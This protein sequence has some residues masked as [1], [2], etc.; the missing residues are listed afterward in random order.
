MH[1]QL[2]FSAEEPEDASPQKYRWELL[3]ETI[4]IGP[5][6]LCSFMLWRYAGELD[7]PSNSGH[8]CLHRPFRSN[9]NA[10]RPTQVNNSSVFGHIFEH[11]R[12]PAPKLVLLS[13]L[14]F[15]CC[16]SSFVYRRQGE[17]P[18]QVLV[19]ALVVGTA[20][21]VAYG[22]GAS[23]DLLLLGYMPFATCASMIISVVSHAVLRRARCQEGIM[24]ESQEKVQLL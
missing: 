24:L 14:G 4:E 20:A 10:N 7:A 1:L 17:D 9:S 22:A 18:F 3:F 16:V 2:S 21:T 19:F 23:P 8:V 11:I 15:G 13:A 6:S 5:A 12:H